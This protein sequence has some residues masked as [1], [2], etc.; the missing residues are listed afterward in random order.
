[1][2]YKWKP[3]KAAKKEFAER[4]Q[5]PIEA[6]AY[7]QRKE[8]KANKRRKGSKFDYTSAGGEYLPTDYQ[9][10]TAFKMVTDS[11]ITPEQKQ[12]ANMVISAFSCNEK[13]HHDNIHLV[14]EYARK[15]I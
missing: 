10:K 2:A 7:Q 13:T 14:N 9:N 15:T 4:M 11:L 5:N 1:M 6:A 3:S 12:A 8:D